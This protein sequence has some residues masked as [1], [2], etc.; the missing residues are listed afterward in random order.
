[1][2][3]I[4]RPPPDVSFNGLASQSQDETYRPQS[5][6]ATPVIENARVDMEQQQLGAAYCENL[7]KQVQEYCQ[8]NKTKRKQEWESHISALEGFRIHKRAT[9]TTAKPRRTGCR[10]C[11]DATGF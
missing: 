4:P 7:Q 10:I 11:S 2:S 3:G 8:R 1:M 9:E 6:G 5:R